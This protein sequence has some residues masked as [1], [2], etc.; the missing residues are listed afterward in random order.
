L[1]GWQCTWPK[2]MIWPKKK[3][4]IHPNE[5]QSHSPPPLSPLYKNDI[6]KTG[7]PTGGKS[8]KAEC[9]LCTLPHT[10]NTHKSSW[11]S[12][13]CFLI[14]EACLAAVWLLGSVWLPTSCRVL[15]I[16]WVSLA[17]RNL[18][19]DF[20]PW[21]AAGQASN[22]FHHFPSKLP[23]CLTATQHSKCADVDQGRWWCIISSVYKFT[24]R[25]SCF[26]IF[27]SMGIESS[28]W[29]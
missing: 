23:Y 13:M 28:G 29:S 24:T 25:H 9:K 10:K 5:N 11:L 19:T 22:E 8:L 27:M 14:I 1:V 17:S 4:Q 6:E 7:N 3:P 2:L 21:V 18:P 16:T 12:G 20:S 15:P 26:H